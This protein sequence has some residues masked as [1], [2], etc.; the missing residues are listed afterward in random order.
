MN[1]HLHSP[2]QLTEFAREF[3]EPPDTLFGK[4]VNRLTNVY[5]NSY[6]SVNEAQQPAGRTLAVGQAGAGAVEVPETPDDS[7][8]DLLP[9]LAPLAS[10]PAA[11][12]AR[13]SLSSSVVSVSNDEA[14]SS[15]G[16]KVKPKLNKYFLLFLNTISVVLV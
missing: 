7:P 11:E 2:T 10:S 8:T 4:I 1:R 14:S 6:N 12:M 9:N 16:D 5:N 3:E 13:S 15:S